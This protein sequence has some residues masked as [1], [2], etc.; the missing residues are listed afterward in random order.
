[1][2]NETSRSL[3]LVC[4][5]VWAG[6][7]EKPLM[8]FLVKSAEDTDIFCLQEVVRRNDGVGDIYHKISS[9]LPDF[10]IYFAPMISDL[11][12]YKLSNITNLNTK[13]AAIGPAILI[14][15]DLMIEKNGDLAVFGE[16]EKIRHIAG[17][18]H[19][20][21]AHN[22][23]YAVVAMN[24]K[25]YTICNLH[26]L[27][28]WPKTD[29]PER[30]KQ[31]QKIKTFMDASPSPKILCGDFNISPEAKSMRILEE[32][33]ID[34]IKTYNIKTTRLPEADDKFSD[35]ILVSPDIKVKEFSV[36]QIRIS[37]HLPLIMKFR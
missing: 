6:M 15:N 21:L 23:I 22:I 31:S 4:L 36:P 34:L 25:K 17:Q 18:K 30:L 27:P 14:R 16:Y 10:S 11:S 24:G 20:F 8:D 32:G 28:A 29:T 2:N 37:D 1:M 33:M 7:I 19:E 35:Y 12:R 9:A 26:G 5:N 3:K 13:D